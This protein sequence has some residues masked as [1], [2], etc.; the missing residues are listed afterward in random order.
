MTNRILYFS[1]LLLLVPVKAQ[2]QENVNQPLT[3]TVPRIETKEQLCK[4]VQAHNPADD[5]NYKPGVDVYGNPVVPADVNQTVNLEIMDPV[6][7]PIVVN[8][9]EG[10]DVPPAVEGLELDAQV[11]TIK[12]YSDGQIEYNGRK[13]ENQVL[14]MCSDG[15]GSPEAAPA[16][17]G[18]AAPDAVKSGLATPQAAPPAAPAAANNEIDGQYPPEQ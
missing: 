12:V 9:L 17:G 14:I 4:T 7:I 1:F 2:A 15:T 10:L 3:I 13:I 8:L 11:S 16:S 18:Q 6:Q 5:V